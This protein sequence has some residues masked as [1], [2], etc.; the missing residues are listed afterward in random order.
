MTSHA[1][2]VSCRPSTIE[3]E[4]DAC[5]FH[6]R[7]AGPWELLSPLRGILPVRAT[8]QLSG[9]L[10]HASYEIGCADGDGLCLI[11]RDGALLQ[12]LELEDL[13]AFMEWQVVN[14]AVEHVGRWKLLLHAGALA[15]GDMGLLLPAPSGGGK[16]TLT[17]A[18]LE[19]GFR[20]CS[21]ELAVVDPCTLELAAFPRNPCIK[22]GSWDL[23]RSRVPWAEGAAVTTQLWGRTLRYLD[24]PEPLWASTPVVVRHVVVPRYVP[25]ASPSLESASKSEVLSLLLSQS[26]SA[27]ALGA[28]GVAAAARLLEGTECYTLRYSDLR[29]AVALIRIIGG[30]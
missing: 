16:S 24:V 10:P 20:L 6:A 9:T 25:M 18:L 29:D 14:D 22:T 5:G 3:L 11:F 12:R 30:C 2:Q 28:I 23:L 4:Y 19:E 26:F 7:I 15:R 27:R 13:S 1:S 8:R 17:V 21:D